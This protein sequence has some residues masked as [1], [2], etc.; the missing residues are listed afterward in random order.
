MDGV[1]MYSDV[2]ISDLLCL[3]L[4]SGSILAALDTFKKIWISRKDYE[5]GG[6]RAI[7]Q[8]TF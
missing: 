1:C 7:D 8:K 3:L 6:A 2:I 5:D 4:Y